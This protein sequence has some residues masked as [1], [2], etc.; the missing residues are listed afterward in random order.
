[1]TSSL[2][3]HRSYTHTVQMPHG[4]W[5]KITTAPYQRTPCRW[6]FALDFTQLVKLQVPKIACHITL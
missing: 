2:L 1:M 5:L 6:L 3:A 4:D